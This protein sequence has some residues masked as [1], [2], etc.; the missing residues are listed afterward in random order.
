LYVIA[1]DY[2]KKEG[3]DFSI[4]LPLIRETVSRLD[5]LT[6]R[7]SQTGPAIRND[8]ETIKRHLA[9]LDTYPDVKKIYEAITESIYRYT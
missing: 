1:D 7:Q 6:P 2:C 3:I 4:M 5:A 8:T 9:L